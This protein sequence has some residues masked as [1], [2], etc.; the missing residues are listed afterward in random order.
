MT[1]GRGDNIAEMMKAFKMSG[2]I[3]KTRPQST[4][5]A[6]SIASAAAF[7]KAKKKRKKKII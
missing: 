5:K 6:L 7:T 1:V 4:K 3:G 2:S